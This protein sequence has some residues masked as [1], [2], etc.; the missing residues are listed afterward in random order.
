MRTVHADTTGDLSKNSC[1]RT[2]CKHGEREALAGFSARQ[3]DRHRRA[4][5]AA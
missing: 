1:I 2:S 3:C 5:N 4:F